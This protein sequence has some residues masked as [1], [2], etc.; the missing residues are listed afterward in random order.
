MTEM[1]M[2]KVIHAAVRR[3]MDRF[4]SALTDFPAGDRTRAQQLGIAWDNFDLQLTFHHEGEHDIAWPALQSIGVSKD[5]LDTLDGEHET[6]A[7]ALGETRSAIKTL[8][9]VATGDSAKTA[10]A[11]FEN[12]QAV[13]LQHLEHEEA[14]LEPVYLKNRE[15]PEIKEMGKKFGKVSPSR[16]GV[17]FAWVLDGA[18]PAEQETVKNEVP[19]PVLTILG[20]F[21]RSYRKNV[22]P[23]W[24]R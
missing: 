4:I 23:V 6:M 12:L 8:T 1:S 21:G 9:R 13:T 2:N 17:F 10:L 11:A 20:F 22:A 24:Q 7:A 16:G 19:G 5:L 18:S 15:T 3:D 14:E